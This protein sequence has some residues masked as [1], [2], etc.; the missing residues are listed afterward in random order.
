MKIFFSF[1]FLIT[2]FNLGQAQENNIKTQAE[3]MGKALLDKDYAAYVGYTYPAIAQQTGGI[4]KLTASIKQQMELLSNQGVKV[5]SIKYGEPSVIIKEKDELQS[6][7]LQTMV[8]TSKEGNIETETG[9][10]A[11]SKDNGKHW[12]FID[13]G[14]KD[15]ETV[16]HTLPNISKKLV[17]PESKPVKVLK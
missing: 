8:F 16:R 15:L 3:M 6:V 10:I 13:P 14:E 17:L 11:I 2:A 7:I 1:L 12:Y 5:I 9:I 4:E